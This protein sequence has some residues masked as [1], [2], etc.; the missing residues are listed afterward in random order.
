MATW[1]PTGFAIGIQPIAAVA[2]AQQH[3]IGTRVWARSET[4]GWGEFVY[5]KGGTSVDIGDWVSYSMLSGLTTVLAADVV[6]PLGISQ[7]TNTITTNYSWFQIWGLSST[8]NAIG[9]IAINTQ[10]YGAGTGGVDDAVVDGDMVHNA[11]CVSTVTGAGAV[12]GA[13]C[14]F[15][16]YP[17]CDN[18]AGND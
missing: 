8:G 18:I 12:T 9:A 14:F 3:P 7:A 13:G 11:L 15:I 17:Y 5:L 6:A 2:T 16:W 10:I 1:L 4:Y